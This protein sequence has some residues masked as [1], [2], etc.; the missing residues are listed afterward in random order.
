MDRKYCNG[1]Q[2]EAVSGCSE[3]AE[4]NLAQGK[5]DNASEEWVKNAHRKDRAE[6]ILE[7]DTV[8]GPPGGRKVPQEPT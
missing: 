7:A 1:S 6:I 2:S 3:E 4:V 5:A 8:S